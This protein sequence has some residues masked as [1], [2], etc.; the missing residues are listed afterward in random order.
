MLK[1]LMDYNIYFKIRP[2]NVGKR[3]HLSGT[4]IKEMECRMNVIPETS[5]CHLKE[6]VEV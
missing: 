1:G 5:C 2:K 4:K 3:K 6:E